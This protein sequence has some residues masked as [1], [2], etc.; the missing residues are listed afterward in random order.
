MDGSHGVKGD[1]DPGEGRGGAQ[2]YADQH[3]RHSLQITTDTSLQQKIVQQ[4]LTHP[5]LLSKH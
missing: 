5:M 2:L 1:P 3:H 4:P